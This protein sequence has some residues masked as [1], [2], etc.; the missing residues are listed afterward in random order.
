[1]K[2]L[3]LLVATA[4]LFT[5]LSSASFEAED[6]EEVR[7]GQGLTA[8][9]L[10]E[11]AP[12]LAILSRIA[13]CESSNNPLATNPKSTAKGLFQITDGTRELVEKHTG[14]TY[15]LFNEQDSLEAALWL[16]ERYKGKPWKSSE[17]CWSDG[18]VNRGISAG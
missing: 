10:L 7:G 13:F 8:Q 5:I 9:N 12:S 6:L 2:T 11:V 4:I 18:M 1:M 16:Y 3:L 14:K 15:D 17:A